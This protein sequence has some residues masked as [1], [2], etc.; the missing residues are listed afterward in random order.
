M[1][2]QWM[3]RR[4][5]QCNI[6][7]ITDRKQAEEA[8]LQNQQQQLQIRDQFLSRM[9]HELR[10]PLTPIHQFVTILLDGL[11]GDLNAEQR[12]YLTIALRQ[13][14]HTPKHGQ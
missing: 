4:V 2:I 14:Q 5:I 8:L 6:R 1:S 9:S 11:A 10:S 13:C 7:D 12:E 3:Q